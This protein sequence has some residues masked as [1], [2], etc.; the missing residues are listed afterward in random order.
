MAAAN[1]APRSRQGQPDMNEVRDEGDRQARYAEYVR[2]CW[3]AHQY[4]ANRQ[5]VEVTRRVVQQRGGA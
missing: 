2:A 5:A 3:L 1:R 4:E